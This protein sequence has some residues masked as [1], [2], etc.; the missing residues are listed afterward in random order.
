MGMTSQELAAICGI[1]RGTVDR[2]LKNRPEVKKETR[3]RVL[4]AARKYG[5]RPNLIGQTLVSGKSRTIGVVLF[6][7]THEFFA[8]LYS[9]FEKGADQKG[10]VTFPVLSYHEPDRE[11]EVINRLMDRRVDAL[12][13][14]PV[15]QGPDF[16]A[17]LHSLSIPIVVMA[18]RLSDAF[19]F[20][21]PDDRRASA[22][23]AQ[24]LYA[25]HPRRIHYFSPPLG[26]QAKT[27]NCYAQIVRR[28]GWLDARQKLHFSGTEYQSASEILSQLEPGDAVLA[29]SDFYALEIQARLR[30]E[31]PELAEKIL[32]MG[33]DGLNILRFFPQ[34][35][36]TVRFSHQEWAEAALSQL[37]DLLA[38]RKTADQ[39]VSHQIIAPNGEFYA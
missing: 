15:N 21:G 10:Y 1:S 5:Y 31:R 14:L 12:I 26:K 16:E 27:T 17:F 32:L 19:A 20:S 34:R 7:F 30:R 35:I 39:S 28:D 9:A 36:A 2:A 33:F 23:A 18:N 4:A 37:A 22:E 6:D 25:Q 29:S 3:E 13:L 8:E 24:Y 38:G 11:I